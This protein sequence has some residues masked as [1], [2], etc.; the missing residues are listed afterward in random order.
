M[1]ETKHKKIHWWSLV[2]IALVLLASVYFLRLFPIAIVGSSFVSAAEFDNAY[3]IAQKLNPGVSKSQVFDQLIINTQ[4]EKLVDRL[5][6]DQDDAIEKESNFY[7]SNSD[8]YNQVLASS[9]KNSENLFYKYVAEPQAMDALLMI[10]YNEDFSKNN[11]AYNKINDILTKLNNG[12]NF[13]DL[14]K[15][16]S[17]DKVSGQLGGDLGFVSSGEFLPELEQ[18]L[19]RL[20]L[21]EKEHP[22]SDVLISRLGYHILYLVDESSKN[23]KTTWHLKHIFIKTSGYEDWVLA[24]LKAISV[25]KLIGV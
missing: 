13:D 11:T 20:K 9:F 5:K 10:K 1:E 21:V 24:Q 23:G 22:W 4:K 14:A 6:I 18:D 17:D 7:K 15:V 8:Q 12:E 3:K 25:K 19:E 2:A 16:Y